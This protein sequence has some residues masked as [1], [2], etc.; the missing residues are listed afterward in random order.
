MRHIYKILRERHGLPAQLAYH[1][2]CAWD[3]F[4]DLEADGLVKIWT[5]ADH[6]SAWEVDFEDHY[7]DSKLGEY[8]IREELPHPKCSICAEIKDAEYIFLC[9]GWRLDHLSSI[10]CSAIISTTTRDELTKYDIAVEVLA[11]YDL[12]RADRNLRLKHL[13]REP[14]IIEAHL[15]SDF[16]NCYCGEVPSAVMSVGNTSLLFCAT[17]IAAIQEQTTK[18]LNGK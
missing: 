10:D 15:S 11:A 8:C 1:Y 18:L 5:E 16:T 17:C 7:H 3:R 4:T 12:A 9:G 6:E 14:R 13:H 2:A